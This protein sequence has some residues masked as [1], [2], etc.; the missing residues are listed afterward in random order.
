MCFLL[1][2]KEEKKVKDQSS[3]IVV[4]S[5]LVD[6]VLS[7]K[8]THTNIYYVVMSMLLMHSQGSYHLWCIMVAV[9]HDIGY[10]SHRRMH[11]LLTG[12]Y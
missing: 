6:F 4:H 10:M 11:V 8:P 2:Y 7:I 1:F 12:I 3:C 9:K 5:R